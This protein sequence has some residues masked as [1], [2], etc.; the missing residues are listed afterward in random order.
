VD[1]AEGL[2]RQGS[3]PGKEKGGGAVQNGEDQLTISLSPL[4]ANF[5]SYLGRNPSTGGRRPRDRLRWW[6]RSR[7]ES[8]REEAAFLDAHLTFVGRTMNRKSKIQRK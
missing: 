7:S 5:Y 3:D 2:L 4:L 8:G 6:S 1:G